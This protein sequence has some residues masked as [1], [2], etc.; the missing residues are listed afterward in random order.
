MYPMIAFTLHRI[1]EME[2]D[3]LNED[4]RKGEE[5]QAQA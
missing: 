1:Q 2:R 4:L 3:K 5:H